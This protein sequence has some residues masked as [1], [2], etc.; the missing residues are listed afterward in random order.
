MISVL[1]GRLRC[2][3]LLVIPSCQRD[4]YAQKAQDGADEKDRVDAVEQCRVL[5][6]RD[7][8]IADEQGEHHQRQAHAEHLAQQAHGADHGRCHPVKPLFDGPHN[9]AGVR[10]DEESQSQAEDDQSLFNKCRKIFDSEHGEPYGELWEK[11]CREA[12]QKLPLG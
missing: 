9:G 8:D 12:L 11:N 1:S 4:E 5:N 6:R 7:P 3:D 2:L 10:R